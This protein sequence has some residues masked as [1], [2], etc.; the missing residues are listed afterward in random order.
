MDSKD[1]ALFI[2]IAQSHLNDRLSR[3]I[4]ESFNQR[5]NIRFHFSSL[6]LKETQNFIIQNIEI[7]GGQKDIFNEN[8]IK[9]VYNISGG[10]IR[11]IGKLCIKTLTLGASKKK[12]IL[13]EED[14]LFAS[15][16]L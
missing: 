15:K 12:N 6:T 16:E 4:M 3:S 1:P 8:A 5:I 7:A 13:T 14:V 10:I 9:S 11:K 2:L